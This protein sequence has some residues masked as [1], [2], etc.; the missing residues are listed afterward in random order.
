MANYEKRVELHGDRYEAYH[1]AAHT[2]EIQRR[3]FAE[4]L[5]CMGTHMHEMQTQSG[6][7][8]FHKVAALGQQH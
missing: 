1:A 7:R 4:T 5:K 3:V 6:R 2:P 8:Y